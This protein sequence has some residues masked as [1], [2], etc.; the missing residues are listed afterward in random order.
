MYVYIN[1]YIYIL[2]KKKKHIIPSVAVGMVRPVLSYVA[3]GSANWSS[4]L[5]KQVGNTYQEP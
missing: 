3:G 4:P 2:K 1:I 5:G